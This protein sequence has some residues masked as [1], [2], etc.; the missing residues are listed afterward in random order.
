[1][2]LLVQVLALLVSVDVFVAAGTE[3]LAYL[4]LVLDQVATLLITLQPALP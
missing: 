4:F 2:V 3:A 1:M